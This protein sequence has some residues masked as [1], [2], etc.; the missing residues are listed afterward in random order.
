MSLLADWKRYGPLAAGGSIAYRIAGRCLVFDVTDLMVLDVTDLEPVQRAAATVRPLSHDEVVALAADPKLDLDRSIASRLRGRLDL[1][2]AAFVGE[3]LA[4]YYW[5]ALDSIEAAHN[6]GVCEE[7]G[8]AVSFPHNAAFAYKAFVHPAFRGQGLYGELVHAAGRSMHQ[9][10]GTRWLISTADW[11][12]H[13]ARRSCYRHGFQ[14]VGRI[15]RFGCLGRYFT[16]APKTAALYGI[17]VGEHATVSS[18]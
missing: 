2:F 16:L 18:R 3:K 12:N 10:Y 5:L 17:R 8:V 13:A 14:F 6:R 4:G 7:S 15:W 11:L 9:R 1:C